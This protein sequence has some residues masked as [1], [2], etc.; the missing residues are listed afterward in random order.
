MVVFPVYHPAAGLHNTRLLGTIREDFLALGA[1]LLGEP[2][3]SAPP[4]DDTPGEYVMDVPPP[5][6]ESPAALDTETDSS[7]C[8]LAVSVSLE[9]G[10]AFVLRDP[11]LIRGY[12][13][14]LRARGTT[15]ALHNALFDMAVLA[16]C[17]GLDWGQVVD[18]IT[19]AVHAGEEE[20]QRGL[21]QL[22]NRRL[23]M[24]M[25]DYDAV[26]RPVYRAALEGWCRAQLE[27]KVK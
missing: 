11:D 2:L 3:R 21:K 26:V 23:G 24:R 14:A 5:P 10:R 19:L 7:S 25:V 8:L 6:G 22:A 20:G 4:A 13:A 1:Y 12:L 27:E 15:V 16:E 17:G 9:R 18:T